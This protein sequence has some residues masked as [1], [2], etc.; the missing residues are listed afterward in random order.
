[1]HTV[2]KSIMKV[3]ISKFMFEMIAKYSNSVFML[4]FKDDIGLRV[5]NF[6]QNQ[7]VHLQKTPYLL[8]YLRYISIRFHW[9][10]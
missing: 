9:S 1:M 5:N 4:R 6:M 10:T 3:N 8:L 2:T 7:A